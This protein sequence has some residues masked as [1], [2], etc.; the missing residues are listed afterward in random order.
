[1]KQT[2]FQW[3]FRPWIS[4]TRFLKIF[5]DYH[6]HKDWFC[7]FKLSKYCLKLVTSI[8]VNSSGKHL[9]YCAEKLISEVFVQPIFCKNTL[10]SPASPFEYHVAKSLTGR[11][12]KHSISLMLWWDL[13]SLIWAVLNSFM[14]DWTWVA[15]CRCIFDNSISLVCV[16]ARLAYF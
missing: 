4:S 3:Y 1:M 16:L 7:A 8:F 5:S 12:R 9:G 11:W 6:L 13:R 2:N 10:V 14:E 15:I